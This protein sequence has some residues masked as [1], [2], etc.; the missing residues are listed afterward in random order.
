MNA[1]ANVSEVCQ[2]IKDVTYVTEKGEVEILSAEQLEFSYRI[3]S[4]QK[5]KGA[6]AAATFS[7]IPSEEARAKQ[8]KIIEYRTRTQP[9][10]DQSAGCIFRTQKSSLREL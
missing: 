3:S 4:F 9:Y 8:L 6:I 1:G 7:L 2:V 5:R 10:G